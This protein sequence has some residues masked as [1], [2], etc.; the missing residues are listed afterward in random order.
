MNS[1]N[2]SVSDHLANVSPAYTNTKRQCPK[3]THF[4]QD[5][6]Q[7]LKSYFR[8]RI[9]PFKRT[10]DMNLQCGTSSLLIQISDDI[11]ECLYHGDEKLVELFLDTSQGLRLSHVH[12]DIQQGNTIPRVSIKILYLRII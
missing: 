8:R 1:D 5:R 2:Y 6:Q 10:Y 12:Q 4:I 3:I 11:Q 7:R 9:V